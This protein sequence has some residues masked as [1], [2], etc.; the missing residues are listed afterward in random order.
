VRLNIPASIS[1]FES[2]RAADILS[3]TLEDEKDGLVR[4]KALRALG[5]LVAS[6]DV[7]IDRV[8]M[9]RLARR[10]LE[11]YVRLLSFRAVLAGH[12]I[13]DEAGRLLCGLLD[14]KL[15]QSMER[16]FRLLKIAHKREDI[17]RV[18]TAA[19]S[20]DSRERANA[21]EF[22]DALLA[23]RDQQ[24]LR[25]LLRIVVDEATDAERVSRASVD[26]RRLART[27]SGALRML[28]EDG[29]D[30]LAALAAQHSLAVENDREL[31]EAVV[32]ASEHRPSLQ[33]ML[34]RLFGAAP[35]LV[36]QEAANG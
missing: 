1:R 7:R 3:Q 27:P 2:Q 23:R 36:P 35:A 14:D 30:A 8:Q 31:R 17:H 34:E 19:L 4:Y 20:R 6:S 33:A 28:V 12:A 10:N 26:G 21:G 29:D 16:A 9:E 5:H 13:T 11:E 24:P 15:R 18:H 32:R 25:Q 22:L